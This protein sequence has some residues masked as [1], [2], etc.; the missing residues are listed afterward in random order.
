VCSLALRCCNFC[1]VVG[2]FGAAKFPGHF[3]ALCCPS[4]AVAASASA[5][6]GVAAF[7]GT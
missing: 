1:G 7:S 3:A 5:S 2:V 6:A 4:D